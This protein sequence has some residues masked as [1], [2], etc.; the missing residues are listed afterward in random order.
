[1][2]AFVLA[3]GYGKRMGTLTENCPKP[4]LKIQGITLLDYSLY[5]LYEWKISK[6]WINTHYLGEKIKEH[7]QKFIKYPIE[8]LVEKEK[9]WELPVEFEQDYRIMILRILFC[10]LILIHYFFRIKTFHLRQV[11]RKMSKF[12]CIYFLRLQVILIQK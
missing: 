12:I 10:L 8:L 2:K 3:A 11:Y 7:I 5:L 1:M 6:V 9:F 4:L